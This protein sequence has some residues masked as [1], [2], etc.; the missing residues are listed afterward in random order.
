[1]INRKASD[2][3][4]RESGKGKITQRRGQIKYRKTEKSKEKYA[5]YKKTNKCK[6][7]QRRFQQTEKGKQCRKRMKAKRRN[8][9]FIKMFPNPFD[10]SELIEYHHITN[11][12][13]VALPRDLHQ[14][15]KTKYHRENMME[16][17]KQ[18]YLGGD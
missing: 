12:Y 16:I 7:A 14:L 17:V 9:N 6:I 10:N 1:M 8:L 13:V 3:K 15:Y 18:I 4:Y 11:A 2:K 5:R